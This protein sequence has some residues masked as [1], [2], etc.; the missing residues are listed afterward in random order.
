MHITTPGTSLGRKVSELCR[1]YILKDTEVFAHE[2]KRSTVII[3]IG[4]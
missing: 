1:L 3:N 4:C 2:A